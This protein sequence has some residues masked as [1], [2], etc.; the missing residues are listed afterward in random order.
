MVEKAA[1]KILLIE[2]SEAIGARILKIISTIPSVELLGQARTAK[3][4]LELCSALIPD[5]IFLDINLP[6][7][8]GLE[9]LKKLKTGHPQIQIIM[10]TNSSHEF[11]RNKCAELGAKF[12]LDKTRDFPRILELIVQIMT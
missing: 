4:G 1:Y 9:L 5:L 3:E 8:S 2:D 11:Y 6:D 10:L 12:F 7:T